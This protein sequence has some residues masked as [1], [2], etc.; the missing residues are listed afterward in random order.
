MVCLLLR[1]SAARLIT[2]EPCDKKTKAREDE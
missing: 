2:D 1:E